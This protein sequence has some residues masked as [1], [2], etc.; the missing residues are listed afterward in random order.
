MNTIRSFQDFIFESTSADRNV[1]IVTVNYG[2]Y[3]MIGWIYHE[4][5]EKQAKD[6]Y[7]EAVAENYNGTDV[8][9]CLEYWLHNMDDEDRAKY[10]IPPGTKFYEGFDSIP[11]EVYVE[12]WRSCVDGADDTYGVADM[13]KIPMSSLMEKLKELTELRL[14]H[15][16][17][18]SYGM[19][20]F[21]ALKDDIDS[22]EM[23]ADIRTYIDGEMERLK[24]IQHG[25]DVF[26]V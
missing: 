1:W 10:G 20:M 17:L 18:E 4:A 14:E 3:E 13:E 8:Y 19:A 7:Y 16:E 15:E 25:R 22:I 9:E 24:K 2:T 6:R 11:L 26:G 5:D 21:H 23:P 12:N